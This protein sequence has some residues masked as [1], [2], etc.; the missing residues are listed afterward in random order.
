MEYRIYLEDNLGYLYNATSDYK[1]SAEDLTEHEPSLYTF[2]I[3]YAL[4][5]RHVD[6]QLY[7]EDDTGIESAT[8]YYHIESQGKNYRDFIF[9][10]SR[11]DYHSG[12]QATVI[13][14]NSIGDDKEE[15]VIRHGPLDAHKDNVTALSVDNVTGLSTPTDQI[16]RA[17]GS[18]PPFPQNT[19]ISY[20]IKVRDYEGNE[21]TIPEYKSMLDP[22]FH[23]SSYIKYY[24]LYDVKPLTDVN[25]ISLNASI[26][27]IN[28]ADAGNLTADILMSLYADKINATDLPSGREIVLFNSEN[29]DLRNV[30]S[31]AYLPKE[32]KFDIH[33]ETFNYSSPSSKKLFLLHGDPLRYP[34]DK[35][36]VNL[37]IEMPYKNVVLS[38]KS[39]V[40]FADSINASWIPSVYL[41]K[42]KIDLDN[43]STE[44]QA[45]CE[46]FELNF[47][48]SICDKENSTFFNMQFQIKRN[49]TIATIIIPLL[50]IFYLLGAIFIFENPSDGISN[51]LALTLGI[52]AL[53]FTLPE[54]INSMKPQTSGPTIADS[55]LSIIIISTIA[56]TVSSVISS[57][58][59]IRN[60]FPNRHTWIDGLVFLGVSGIII[61]Y[62]SNFPLDISIWLIP[63]I[64]FGL[65]YG[66]LLRIL[67]I[68][69]T[70]P[71]FGKR[72]GMETKDTN[73]YKQV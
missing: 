62:L 13:H 36:S 48:S 58:S 72:K 64:L 4:P 17:T 39:S 27:D 70:R 44:D 69:I 6:L 9:D 26:L 43:L 34:F 18:L 56:F 38:N 7:L 54:I 12:D 42:S 29:E 65:G 3:T 60:W 40:N 8:L 61:G 51:R 28:V 47:T 19:I 32:F 5:N 25:Q 31:I 37:I 49:Y 68:K 57:S 1:V 10:E 41:S 45:V 33:P 30:K 2:G 71:V 53:I 16:S 66:L 67:G 20:Y 15:V 46:E 73:T 24:L 55:L 63:I 50:A 11:D 14:K 59:I 21:I 22:S 52:F 35:Y 23:E